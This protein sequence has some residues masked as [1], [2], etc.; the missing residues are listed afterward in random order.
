MP[1]ESPGRLTTD[2]CCSQVDR[3]V[4]APRSEPDPSRGWGYL[5]R[6]NEAVFNF[7]L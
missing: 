5:A 1:V 7:L 2:S 3:R 4:G 6:T